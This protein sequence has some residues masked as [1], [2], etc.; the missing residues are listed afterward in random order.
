MSNTGY[1]VAQ[2]MLHTFQKSE[3]ATAKKTDKI[4]DE[5][6]EL[7]NEMKRLQVLLSHVAKDTDDSNRVDWSSNPEMMELVDEIRE[8]DSTSHIF[9]HGT[10][11]WKGEELTR[12]TERL[13]GHISRVVSPQIQQNMTRLNQIGQESNETLEIVATGVKEA[14]EMIRRIQANIQRA[15]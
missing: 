8:H 7:T 3:V 11:Q 12:L 5:L 14:N 1:N 10:Y 9:E 15:R 6:D 13:N 2:E 4:S